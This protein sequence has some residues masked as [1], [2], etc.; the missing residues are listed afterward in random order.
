[1]FSSF[2]TKV[3]G[4]GEQQDHVL[5]QH[6]AQRVQRGQRLQWKTETTLSYAPWRTPPQWQKYNRAR[7]RDPHVG[8]ATLQ[9]PGMGLVPP[10]WY[11]AL[12]K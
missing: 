9:L 6:E 4:D 1:M 12:D 11:L 10:L 5:H 7:L 3:G 8:L 2:G